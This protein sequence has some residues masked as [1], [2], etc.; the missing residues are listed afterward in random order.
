LRANSVNGLTT[1]A[2]T[3]ACSLAVHLQEET[4]T[5]LRMAMPL[6]RFIG[7]LNIYRRETRQSTANTHRCCGCKALLLGRAIAVGE[8]RDTMAGHALL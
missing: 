4:H 6:R 3:T 1:A 8:V 2:P 5:L 7:Q